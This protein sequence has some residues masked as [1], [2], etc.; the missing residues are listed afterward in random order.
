MNKL[1]ISEL[2]NTVDYGINIPKNTYDRTNFSDIN[3]TQIPNMSNIKTIGRGIN[4]PET[5]SLIG[6]V[7][8]S[9]PL[10]LKYLSGK[11]IK[12]VKNKLKTNINN[13]LESQPDLSIDNGKTKLVFLGDISDYDLINM[14]KKTY[15]EYGNNL[16]NNLKQQVCNLNKITIN[17]MTPLLITELKCQYNYLRDI[18]D[19]IKPIQ[20]PLN[21]RHVGK[22]MLP[23]QTSIWGF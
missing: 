10:I 14:M 16:P 7:N 17:I 11:N 3:K 6:I 22:K 18:N 21:V 15:Y 19:P 1:S 20:L 9:D 2:S 12:H 4:A 23:S 5:P 13:E 8:R